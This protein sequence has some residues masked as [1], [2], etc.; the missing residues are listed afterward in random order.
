MTSF[1]IKDF[2]F[3]GLLGFLSG[4]ALS[5]VVLRRDEPVA[6][7]QRGQMVQSASK[8]EI[9]SLLVTLKFEHPKGVAEFRKL[10]APYAEWVAINEPTTTSYQLLQ[11]VSLPLEVLV[12]ERYITKEAYLN[13]HRKS[14]EFISFKERFLQ[15]KDASETAFAVS[16]NSYNDTPLGFM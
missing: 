11:H 12:L 4:L 2:A 15:L 8:P 13:I 3:K 16:G 5:Y 10:F 14:K 9:F 6:P 1:Q 7:S